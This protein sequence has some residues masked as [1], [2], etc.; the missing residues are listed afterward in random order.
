MLKLDAGMLGIAQGEEVLFSDF[1]NEGSMW[2]GNGPREVRHAVSFAESFSDNP[3]VSVSVSMFDAS[4][5]TN[6]RF[7]V[8]A[9]GVTPV[10]F[11][12]V[13]RTWSDSQIA[14][15]RVNWQAIGAVEGE[16]VWDI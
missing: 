8:K 5:S 16:E 9:E 7:D 15:A 10:G 14:R 3:S 2:S 6:I 4:S 12:I 11:D 1:E 13:F